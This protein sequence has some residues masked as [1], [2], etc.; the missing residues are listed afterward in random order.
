VIKELRNQGKAVVLVEHNMEL[1]R[2]LTDYLYVLDAGALLAEGN[3][4]DVLERKEV[5]E[6]Y[7]GE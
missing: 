3:P 4:M 1:I 5:M 6:A 7:L 2:T